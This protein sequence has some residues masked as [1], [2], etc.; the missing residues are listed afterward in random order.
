MCYI[1]HSNEL[2]RVAIA[3]GILEILDQHYMES[4]GFK[5]YVDPTTGKSHS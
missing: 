2:M 5:P 3:Q 1:S 4:L